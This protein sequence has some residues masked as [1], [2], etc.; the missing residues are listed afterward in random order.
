M[1]WKCGI[2]D[3]TDRTKKDVLKRGRD[4]RKIEKLY[5]DLGEMLGFKYF[6]MGTTVLFV[7]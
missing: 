6:K 4:E 1:C 3:V 5:E 7:W 2:W